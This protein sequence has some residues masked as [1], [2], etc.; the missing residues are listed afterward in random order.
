VKPDSPTDV[1]IDRVLN[2]INTTFNDQHPVDP[3]ASRLQEI[4]DGA[5]GGERRLAVRALAPGSFA[6]DDPSTHHHLATVEQ[7]TPRHWS[8][9][10]EREAH[11]SHVGV[12]GQGG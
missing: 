11:G 12:P 7:D 2:A 8:V 1:E 10:R 3:P 4:A 9:R 5:C 6:L